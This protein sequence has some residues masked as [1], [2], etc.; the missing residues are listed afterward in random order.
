MSKAKRGLKSLFLFCYLIL[1]EKRNITFQVH[2][3][4]SNIKSGEHTV[5][6]FYRFNVFL[7]RHALDYREIET[8]QSY[9]CVQF[10]IDLRVSRTI[11]NGDDN[12]LL[13]F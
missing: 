10:N 7:Y 11:L 8:L 6:I 3:Y 12:M 5:K 2:R 13:G 1:K 4:R 9:V